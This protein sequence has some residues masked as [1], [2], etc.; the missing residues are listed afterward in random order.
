MIY[1]YYIIMGLF[2]CLFFL[3]PQ[4]VP[5]FFIHQILLVFFALTLLIS[6]F[7]KYILPNLLSIQLGKY[8]LSNK[9]F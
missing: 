7:S 8:T 9:V 6:L 3:M 5:F 1:I 2:T 4:L